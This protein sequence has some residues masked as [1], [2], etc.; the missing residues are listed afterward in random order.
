MCVVSSNFSNTL[1]VGEL[2]SKVNEARVI[3][4]K[5][6]RMSCHQGNL[7]W[8]SNFESHLEIY[9]EGSYDFHKN[10][11]SLGV[12]SKQRQRKRACTGLV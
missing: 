1:I 2:R 4:K 6:G 12:H 7:V 9:T 8:K 5:H 3:F 10:L 11:M